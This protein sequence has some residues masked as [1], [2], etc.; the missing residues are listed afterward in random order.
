MKQYLYESVCTDFEVGK[1]RFSIQNT[2]MKNPGIDTQQFTIVAGPCGVESREQ[3][4]VIADKVKK[5]GA[6]ILRGGAFKPRTSPYSFQGLGADGIDLLA[7]VSKEIGLP[8]V[9]EIV[10]GRDLKL[11]TGIDILQVGARNMFNYALL[12]EL[13]KVNKPILLKRGLGATINE[14]LLSA[15][16]LLQEGNNKVILCERGIRVGDK[17]ILDLNGVI[18]IRQ[19]TNLPIIVDTTHASSD[20]QMVRELALASATLDIQ[21]IMLEVSNDK[22][23]AKSD[24]YRALSV[25]EF[26]SVVDKIQQVRKILF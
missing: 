18:E 9:S 16:Y 8:V 10:D 26:A 21:G 19:R 4:F 17:T 11:F 25:D 24:G 6:T 5:F 7:T 1:N 22:E 23:N 2:L 12:K 3:L 15:E 13:A 20:N 14:W